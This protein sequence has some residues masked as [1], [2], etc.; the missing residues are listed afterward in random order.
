MW[1]T[2]PVRREEIPG[3]PVG[4]AAHSGPQ[5]LELRPEL[6]VLTLRPGTKFRVI[7]KK[8]QI[9]IYIEFGFVYS[10]DRIRM[11]LHITSFRGDG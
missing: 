10:I 2:F 7:P 11:V 3:R 5:L 8:V 9:T 1:I 4:P 6:Q